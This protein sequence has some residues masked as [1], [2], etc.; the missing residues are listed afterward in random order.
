[1]KWEFKWTNPYENFWALFCIAH[2]YKN[3]WK[4][5]I[6]LTELITLEAVMFNWFQW[7]LKSTNIYKNIWTQF[8]HNP[9]L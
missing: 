2:T 7:E 8:Y 5:K 9:H 3:F 4:T 6:C 1:M